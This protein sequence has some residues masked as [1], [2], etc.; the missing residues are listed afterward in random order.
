MCS[1]RVTPYF[2]P[3]APRT[4][5][6]VLQDDSPVANG[7][8]DDRPT[9]SSENRRRQR[10]QAGGPRR[11]ACRHGDGDAQPVAVDV[12]PEAPVWQADVAF[13]TQRRLEWT[14]RILETE[15]LYSVEERAAIARGMALLGSLEVG[16]GKVKTL[17]RTASTL[18]RPARI[19]H[20]VRTGH[21]VGEA[22]AVVH[23]RDGRCR[24][25]NA[26]GRPARRLHL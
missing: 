8:H 17:K 26:A 10:G 20:D 11:D 23:V 4:G 24:V 18:R 9:R 15:Q 13:D 19:K 12:Q 2:T 7:D 14:R 21:L 22:E 5:S 3:V 1:V 25:L 16:R 6:S